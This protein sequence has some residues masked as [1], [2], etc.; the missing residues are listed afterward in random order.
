MLSAA[1]AATIRAA[2]GQ[3][4]P[5]MLQIGRDHLHLTPVSLRQGARGPVGH[6]PTLPKGCDRCH[7]VPERSRTALLLPNVG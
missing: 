3:G 5:A 1:A 7:S 2:E 6:A 4:V